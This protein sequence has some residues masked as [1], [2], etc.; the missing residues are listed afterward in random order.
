MS[1]IVFNT[2]P[3]DG[4]RTSL[5]STYPD[6]A[7]NSNAAVNRVEPLLTPEL[8]KSRHLFGIPLVSPL[9]REKISDEMLKDS[10][11]RAVN[12]AETQ[13][14][15]V[16]W[17]T[18]FK[19]KFPF[20]RNLY[21][22][23]VHINI[24]KTPIFSLQS[25]TITTADGTNVFVMPQRWIE[26]SNFH[27][28]LLNVI[29]ISPAFAALGA[30]TTGATGGAVFLTFIGQLGWIPAYWQAE[31]I[32]GFDDKAIPVIVN[33]LI[34]VIAAMDVLSPLAATKQTTS[35]NLSADGLGQGV[36]TPGPQTY[37]IRMDELEVKRQQILADLKM[38]YGQSMFVGS[39]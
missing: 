22:Q 27:K 33:E 23:W 21:Q 31:W 20:D 34:G 9:T 14:K 18:Q 29:P 39:V 24:P 6:H 2:T 1:P 32:A 26:T 38:M 4:Q 11:V 25:L 10:I 8:L 35:H 36:S 28:G 5:G 15:L 17:L 16:I 19:Q 3:L 7:E 37:K 12:R 30:Q 13:S